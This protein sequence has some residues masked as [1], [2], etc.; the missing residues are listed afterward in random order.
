MIQITI[1]HDKEKNIIGYTMEG[2]S[3]YSD[4]GSDI[5]CAAVSALAQTALLGLLKQAPDSVA[6]DM[7]DGYLSVKL[8]RTSGACQVILETMVLGLQEI[9]KQYDT[10]VMLQV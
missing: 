2:H 4:E 10:Y 8:D 7:D 6:Y 9:A 3:G 1:K 5:I